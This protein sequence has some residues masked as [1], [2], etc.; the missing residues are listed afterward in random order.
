MTMLTATSPINS[1]RFLIVLLHI[2]RWADGVSRLVVEYS[3]PNSQIYAVRA[4]SWSL[5]GTTSDTV[6]L[7]RLAP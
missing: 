3:I 5:M 7:R 1:S 2:I 6:V 4:R